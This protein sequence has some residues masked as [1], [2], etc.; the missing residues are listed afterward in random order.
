M[1]GPVRNEWYVVFCESERLGA[2]R[3]FCKREFGHCYCF[4]Q[5]SASTVI[6]NY[7]G[8]RTV[9]R[10][11]SL[12]ADQFAFGLVD[13]GARVLKVCFDSDEEESGTL[14]GLT[15]CVSMVKSCLGLRNCFAFTPYALFK[16]L[17]KSPLEV[18]DFNEITKEIDDGR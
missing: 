18:Y 12:S 2:S 6:L 1:S 17:K 9:V 5:G 4:S 3:P 14:R 13:E 11:H 7:D 8:F 10:E 15:Y 16:W